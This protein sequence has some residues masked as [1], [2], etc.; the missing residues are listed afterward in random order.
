MM[1]QIKNSLFKEINLYRV[2]IL[3][4]FAGVIFCPSIAFKGTLAGLKLWATVVLPG[5][6]PALI[7]TSCILTLFPMNQAVSYLYVMGAGLFCGFP[8]GSILCGQL[9]VKNRS[10]IIC[11]KIMAY[12]N[13]SS[14]SFIMNYIIFSSIAGRFSTMKSL[15]CIY[16][17]VLE[18]YL[19]SFIRYRKEIFFSNQKVSNKQA[20]D[21]V[22]EVRA[23]SISNYAGNKTSEP[24]KYQSVKNKI[25]TLFDTSIWS[26]IKSM[27]KLGGYITVFSCLAAYINQIPLKNPV[28]SA[29]IC[30]I[31]EI[32]NGIYLCS[33]LS[34]DIRLI[35]L[36]IVVIN[37]FGGFSTLMQTAGMTAGSGLSIKKYIYHKLALTIVTLVNALV[38]IYVL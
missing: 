27:L 38:I 26:S 31:T 23:A 6:F 12:C 5:L 19:Y 22:H 29:V 34:I 11:D 10:E 7:I 1:K 15:L 37:A 24:I 16:L 4:S 30:G 21:R 13:L 17:P 9:H 14:P 36:L 25:I 3:L 33:K 28:I 2:L 8:V 18:L 35:V 32:T 20:D